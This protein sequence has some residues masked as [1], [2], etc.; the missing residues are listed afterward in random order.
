MSTRLFLSLSAAVILS[1]AP[2]H[3]A[4][5]TAYDFAFRSIDGGPLPMAKFKGKAI[6]VVNTAS[7][8]GFTHQYAD[9]QSVWKAYRARG[10]I[11]LGVPSND[12]G[13]QEPGTKKQIKEFCKVNFNIDFPLTDKVSVK[14]TAAHPF[15][16]WAV[17]QLGPRAAPRWN[18]HKYLIG[19]DGRL[20]AWFPSQVKPTSKKIVDAIGKAL[21]KPLSN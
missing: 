3:A 2:A 4:K 17:A 12:F 13:S 19:R 5:K 15:Y 16:K 9:L 7:F 18:F 11:V 6:L 8:C 1:L 14:G 21:A 10:L 20:I